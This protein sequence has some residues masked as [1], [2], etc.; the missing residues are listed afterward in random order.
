M[1]SGHNQINNTFYCA[2]RQ[3]NKRMAGER[4]ATERFPRPPPVYSHPTFLRPLPSWSTGPRCCAVPQWG[5]SSHVTPAVPNGSASVVKNGK[6]EGFNF[7]V[8]I[9]GLNLFQLRAS[10][11]CNNW[12]IS[13]LTRRYMQQFSNANWSSSL[14]SPFS[15]CQLLSMRVTE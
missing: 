1:C 4:H 12:W 10:N 2:K 14:P 13:S 5:I 8:F 6:L 7:N 11:L 3:T 15:L 9:T